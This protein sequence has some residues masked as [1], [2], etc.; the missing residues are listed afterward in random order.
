MQEAYEKLADYIVDNFSSEELNKVLMNYSD[1]EAYLPVSIDSELAEKLEAFIIQDIP[2]NLTDYELRQIFKEYLE[3][4]I[5]S[6][7]SYD[8]NLN[9]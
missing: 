9:I 2:L 4:T 3:A 1:L 7:I 6:S 5:T 8:F